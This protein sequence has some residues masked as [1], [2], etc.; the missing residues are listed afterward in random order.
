MSRR[1][2]P[3]G[4]DVNK[5]DILALNWDSLTQPQAVIIAALLGA[6]G[7][8]VGALIANLIGQSLNSRASRRRQW[9]EARHQA[10]SSFI[11]NFYVL[12]DSYDDNGAR[13]VSEREESERSRKFLSA[14]ASALLIARSKEAAD[15]IESIFQTAQSFWGPRAL[16]WAQLE[17]N[18]QAGVKKF[19]RSA[20]RE[21][22]IPPSPR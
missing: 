5:G 22:G 14:Y 16:G 17:E 3:T 8:I 10:Y 9:G 2:S 18:C 11:E 21:L 20:R 7:A 19:E 15:A 6:G 12:W 4:D 1:P 13:A